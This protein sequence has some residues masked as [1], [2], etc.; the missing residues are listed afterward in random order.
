M[1]GYSTVAGATD[2][3]GAAAGPVCET[4]RRRSTDRRRLFEHLHD[5]VPRFRIDRVLAGPAATHLRYVRA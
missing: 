1:F 3:P 5:P 4:R 2:T